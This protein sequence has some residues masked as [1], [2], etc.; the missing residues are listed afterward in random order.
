[1]VLD[2]YGALVVQVV[3]I[4]VVSMV[5]LLEDE[6]ASLDGVG[7]TLQDLGGVRSLVVLVLLGVDLLVAWVLA[8]PP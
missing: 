5:L 2:P 6:V 3:L 1:M 8:I 7:S 4:I